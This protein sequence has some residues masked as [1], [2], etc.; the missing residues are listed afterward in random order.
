MIESEVGSSFSE[1]LPTSLT[2][3]FTRVDVHPRECSLECS[4]AANAS[5]T[6]RNSEI[7]ISALQ[8][9]LVASIF[10]DFSSYKKCRVW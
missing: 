5:T 6:A 2:I 1:H 8:A 9:Y 3:P 4:I 10:S 7:L